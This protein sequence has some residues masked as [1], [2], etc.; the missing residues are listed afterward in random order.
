VARLRRR[1]RFTPSRD[2]SQLSAVSFQLNQRPR[3]RERGFP[4]STRNKRGVRGVFSQSDLRQFIPANEVH[5][6]RGRISFSSPDGEVSGPTTVELSSGGKITIRTHIEH[7]V[8]PAEYRNLLMPF[9]H[10]AIPKQDGNKTVFKDRGEHSITGIEV[11]VADGRFR[12]T[13]GLVGG[14]H[15]DLFGNKNATLDIVPG[16]LEFVVAENESEELWCIPLFGGLGEFRGCENACS[17]T[18]H[19]PYIHFVADGHSC[20]VRIFEPSD[21]ADDR[22]FSAVAFGAVDGR[23]HGTPDEVS[24]LIPWGLFPAL[25]FSCGG[26]VGSPWIEL[27]GSDRQL[28]RRIH[29]RFGSR[30]HKEG[31]P[32]FSLFDSARAD[33]G[34]SAFMRRFFN[35]P[36]DIRRL[37]TPAMNLIRSGAPGNVSVDGSIA[38]L[39]KALDAIC[40]RHNL[41]RQN[42]LE[43]LDPANAKS[44]AD[45]TVEARERLGVIRRQCKADGKLDQVAVIDRIVSRQANVATSETDFG[46]AVAALLRKANLHDATAMNAYYSSLPVDVTW[47]GLLSSIRG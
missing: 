14:S 6:G 40:K 8:I 18:D 5:S 22:R 38:D 32:A 37:L 45:V 24:A 11:T 13:R 1:H 29:F 43:N 3:S 7:Y 33:S 28:R 23:P 42:L 26:D 9:L 12:G 31:Y 4:I 10:G 46:V 16:D 27:R 41:T 21:A 34:I 25:E 36:Q 39:V 2:V 15:I 44:V 30:G 17:I 35:L 47:E 20:G 19:V